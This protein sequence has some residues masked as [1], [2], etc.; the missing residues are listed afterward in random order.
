MSP[1]KIVVL[2]ALIALAIADSTYTNIVA[3]G[4]N[5]VDS[6]NSPNYAVLVHHQ[7]KLPTTAN[8]PTDNI[9]LLWLILKP[10]WVLPPVPMHMPMMDQ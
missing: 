10:S 2:C 1:S 5:A 4:F 3:G 6:L 9:F 8:I 7:L